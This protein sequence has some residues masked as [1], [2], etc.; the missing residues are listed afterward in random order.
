MSNVTV[1]VVA[2]DGTQVDITDDLA[3]LYDTATGSMNWG[4]GMLDT[5]E[6][7]AIRRLARVVGYEDVPYEHDKCAN[8]THDRASHYA[9]GCMHS[10]VSYTERVLWVREDPE[11]RSLLNHPDYCGCVDFVL[12]EEA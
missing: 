8:C 1:L 2:P 5:S 3:V 12:K 9:S 10:D 7:K 6:V 11:H 4:S